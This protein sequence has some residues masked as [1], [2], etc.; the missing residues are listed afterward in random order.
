[1]SSYGSS[2]E[3]KYKSA[4]WCKIVAFP[5]LLYKVI[6]LLSLTAVRKICT[7]EYVHIQCNILTSPEGPIYLCLPFVFLCWSSF[8]FELSI[9]DSPPFFSLLSLSHTE[10][11]SCSS[12]WSLKTCAAWLLWSCCGT[13]QQT[14]KKRSFRGCKVRQTSCTL[15]NISCYVAAEQG[16][17]H[18]C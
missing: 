16:M 5:K 9:S 8:L 17:V 11:R 10:Y 3:V 2:Q 15:P 6:I 14:Q 12:C 18:T 13:N 1:M 4:K 7:G